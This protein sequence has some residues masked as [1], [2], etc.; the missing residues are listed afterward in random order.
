MPPRSFNCSKLFLNLCEILSMFINV[1]SSIFNGFLF[2]SA[3]SPRCYQSYR[4]YLVNMNESE[5]ELF[6]FDLSLAIYIIF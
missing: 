5:H 6:S 4:S 1:E 3:I 2:A